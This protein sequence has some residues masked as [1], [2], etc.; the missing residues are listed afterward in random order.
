MALKMPGLIAN[1]L[2]S[3]TVVQ[4]SDTLDNDICCSSF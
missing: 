1:I 4:Q 3:E 2:V